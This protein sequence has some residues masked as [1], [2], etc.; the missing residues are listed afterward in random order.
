MATRFVGTQL[1]TT[2][3]E[4]VTLDELH[5]AVGVGATT[6]NTTA[7]P[8]TM[9]AAQALSGIFINNLAGA[10]AIT[11]PSAASM[12]ATYPNVQ[13]GSQ[14]VLYFI[15]TT[16][17]GT[18]TFT[19]GTGNTF[20]GTTTLPTLTGQILV[21]KFTNVTVGSEAVTW[22]SVLHTAS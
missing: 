4:N 8:I 14:F 9:T 10:M 2:D 22:T 6:T 16:T 7:S 21:G 15:N 13:V 11:L 12:V 5:A 1:S 20:V 19:A 17:S 3:G 18:V